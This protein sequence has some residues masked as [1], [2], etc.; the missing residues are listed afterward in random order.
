[1]CDY[2]GL[3]EIV[4]CFEDHRQRAAMSTPKSTKQG[5]LPK[6]YVGSCNLYRALA[7]TF[8]RHIMLRKIGITTIT[9]IRLGRYN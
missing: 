9:H 3:R 8:D 7:R 2:T 5:A 1:M 6:S 4:L